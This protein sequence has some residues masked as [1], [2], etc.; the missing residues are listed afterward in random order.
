MDPFELNCNS[1]QQIVDWLVD[2]GFPHQPPGTPGAVKVADYPNAWHFAGK[3]V[4]DTKIVRVFRPGPYTNLNTQYAIAVIEEAGVVTF[5]V[6]NLTD[7][8][9]KYGTETRIAKN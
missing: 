7:T 3:Q 2:K 6:N 5:D 4:T 9:A 8:D 1:R